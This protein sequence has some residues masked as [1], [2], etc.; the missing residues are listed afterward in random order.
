MIIA[1]HGAIHIKLSNIRFNKVL[2]IIL[3]NIRLSNIM[4]SN[5][6][7]SNIRPSNIRLSNIRLSNISQSVSQEVQVSIAKHGMVK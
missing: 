3:S 6:R 7:L 5:I 4:L 1:K 2:L